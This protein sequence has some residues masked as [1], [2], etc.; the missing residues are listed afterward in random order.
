M[1][2]VLEAQMDHLAAITRADFTADMRAALRERHPAACAPMT[3]DDLT[4]RIEHGVARSATYGIEIAHDVSR[5]IDLMFQLGPDFDKD[6]DWARAILERPD[7]TGQIRIDLLC[8]AHEGRI[9][10][11]PED[12]PFFP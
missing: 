9:P 6:V 1:L 7:F 3:D 2:K 4:A 11:N 8:A 10:E 12:G 5:Y